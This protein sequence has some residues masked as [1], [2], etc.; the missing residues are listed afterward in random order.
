[1][2]HVTLNNGVKMPQLGFGVWQVGDEEAT[3]AV[4][5]AL[6]VG[7]TS[8]DTAMI[9][10]NEAGVGKAIKEANVNREDLFI[11]TKVWNSDQGFD[12]TIAAFEA[13]LERL[14]L[15]YVDLYLI[16]WPTPQYDEYVD[17][18]KALEKLYKDGRVKAI[19]VCN[20]E[21]EHLERLLKETEIVPVLNQVE[22]HPY[23]AQNELKD[24]CKK[25]DIFVEA[26]SPLDQ[27][28]DVLKDE[29]VTA[30]AEKLGKTAAQVVLRWHL[31]NDTIVIPKSVT[32]S[33]IEENFQ[34]FDFELSAEDMDAINKLDAG[35]RKGAHP[36][37]MN[38]R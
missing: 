17:T 16:H 36:N 19:G 29:V 38:K 21:I 8:I 27:G 34:V 23:L 12:N 11:T 30:I 9:Y 5:K 24:F 7:Y 22:C 6:E 2:N 13:S 15:E 14:G 18:F 20:F 32:P 26:W 1:M 35:R 33:R 37:D 31:Q 10:K 25:H 28:G 4:A 3:A